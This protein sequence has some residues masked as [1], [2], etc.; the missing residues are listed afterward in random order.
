[1]MCRKD[2]D[3]IASIVFLSL[4][5]AIMPNHVRASIT[6]IGDIDPLYDG[7]DPWS[8]DEFLIIGL[9]SDANMIISDGSKVYDS[10]GDIGYYNTANGRVTVTGT[11]SLWENWY[12]LSVGTFGQAE[13]TISN[14]GLVVNHSMGQVGGG[15][16][17]TVSG[18]NSRWETAFLRVEGEMTISNGGTV[19][20]GGSGEIGFQGDGTVHVTGSNSLWQVSE[21]LY[22]GN[23]DNAEL[24]ISSGGKVTDPCAIVG[25]GTGYWWSDESGYL[26]PR[27]G[28]VT[29]T[30]SGSRWE[31]YQFLIV[32]FMGD[33]EVKIADSGTVTSSY[34]LV[35]LDPDVLSLDPNLMVSDTNRVGLVTVTG[36]GS[37]WQNSENLIVGLWRGQGEL[38]ISSGGEVEDTDGYIGGCHYSDAGLPSLWWL[39]PNVPPWDPNGIGR[40]TVTGLSSIWENSGNLY[41]G[42]SGDANMVISEGGKVT[43]A[44]AFIGYESSGVGRVN[45][46]GRNSLWQNSGNLYVGGSDTAAYGMGLLNISDG[47]VVQAGDVTIWPT[48]TISGDGILQ[49]DTVTNRGTIKPGKSIGILTV[50]SDFTFEPNSVL[51]VEVDNSGNSDNLLVTGDVNIVGGTV[52]AISTETITGL[53][54]YTIIEANSVTGTFDTLDTALLELGVSG[55]TPGLGYTPDTVLLNITARRFDFLDLCR[56]R[57]QREVGSAL[58]QIA[59]AGGNTITTGVQGLETADQVRSSYDQL[60]GQIRPPLSPITVVDTSK[61]VGIVSN[62]LQ[63]A[64]TGI[65]RGI[66][67]GPILAMARPDN[68]LGSGRAYDVSPADYTFALGNGS[69]YFD[70]Q[71]WGVWAKVYGLYGDRETENGVPGYLYRIYGQSL[72]FDFQFSEGLLVGITGGF[73]NGYV[74]YFASTDRSELD[75]K[76]IGLYGS[77]NAGRWYFDSILTYVWPTY[78]TKRLVDLTGEQLEGNFDGREISGYFEAGF[79][80]QPGNNWLIQPLASFQFSCLDMDGYT[81]TGGAS[82]LG[83]DK[84]S[85]ESSRGSIGG[86]VRKELT[87]NEDGRSAILEVRGRWAHEFGD[88]QSCVDAHFASDPGVVFTV[89]DEH[90]SRDSAVLGAG[91]YARL[92]KRLRVY[93]DY[94]MSQNSDY[95]A[96]VISAAA[97]YRW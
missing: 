4:V 19:L 95:T 36:P 18:P 59:E 90:I 40:V 35:G 9:D 61:F 26:P 38:V 33:G 66:G 79:D 87:G 56:T 20:T 12:A 83:Y 86:K 92:N 24:T 45:V 96:H 8:I 93:I 76:Y 49:A 42:F 78:Q 71:N 64:H 48:G 89:S 41:V 15:G 51:E 65:M 77:Y 28:K 55:L 63:S 60:C 10:E 84:Q 23:S 91:F 81:E 25:C 46:T 11:S 1:M 80:W 16:H 22:I 13:L 94:D 37:I 34:G 7:S 69:P 73:S 75:G 17:V 5:T 27:T 31:N 67:S 21:E 82:A 68:T 2:F 58:Q 62:R 47:G 50:E 29:V 97:E 52:K 3:F 74:N 88:A 57:N 30:G 14:G 54:Q 70:D 53:K 39:D 85:Y 32:G 6:T 44:N 72:G 43:D